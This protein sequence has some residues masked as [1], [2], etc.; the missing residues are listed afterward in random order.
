[1]RR[2]SE[3]DLPPALGISWR[4]HAPVAHIA[5]RS[6]VGR[7]TP[8]RHRLAAPVAVLL[9]ALVGV[10]P[11]SA[12]R[13]ASME[14]SDP[15]YS[16]GTATTSTFVTFR[17]TY[18]HTGGLAPWFVRVHIGGTAREMQPAVESDAWKHGV[19][20][21]VTTQ[22][23]A[24]TWTPWFEAQRNDLYASVTME[25]PI[26]VIGPTP[27]PT[28]RPT[29]TATPRPTPT[30]TPKPTP[31]PTPAATPRP[32]P[33]AT[34]KSTP[35]PTTKPRPSATDTPP[36]T[37]KPASDGTSTPQPSRSPDATT[38]PD[39][40]PSPTP[41]P[42]LAAI[43]PGPATGGPGGAGGPDG[44][45]GGGPRNDA[46]P[47]LTGSL[48][49]APPGQQ[50]LPMV[51]IAVAIAGGLTMLMAF[52]LFGRRRRGDED[53]DEASLAASA[54]AGYPPSLTPRQAPANGS[55]AMTAMA[56]VPERDAHLPR[57][58]RPSLL[59]AR[60]N[61]PLRGGIT[62]SATLTFDRQAGEVVEGM[63]RRRI[64]YRLV[65]LLN[66]PDEVQGVEIASLDEGDEV[67]L[68]EKSGTYWRVLCPD[69]REGWLHKMTL[70]DTV[71]DSPSA[72]NTWTTGDDGQGGFED[73]MRAY[74]ESRRQFGQ[75]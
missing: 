11:A 12:A 67:L 39:T 14:L 4:L 69:G 17:V 43:H 59:E 19:A 32:T 7:R 18:R 44:D 60:K 53:P 55:S 5:V 26:T 65:S 62:A 28:P 34:P 50:L 1:M 27:T 41:D 3:L 25:G 47:T 9:V 6:S 15:S 24:G 64:R 38:S 10:V 30:P 31:K 66:L 49:Q 29:P 36:A 45:F 20:F 21:V 63:G 54:S 74:A 37:A 40:G 16:P 51:A 42:G 23:P 70:G 71:I 22:L 75:T 46:N 13:P 68:L 2:S 8:W 58:R 57:W 35:K 56:A 61:D 52:V 73:I 48:G 33:I 72:P